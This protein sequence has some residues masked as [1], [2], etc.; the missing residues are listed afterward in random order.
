M[1]ANKLFGYKFHPKCAVQCSPPVCSQNLKCHDDA[2]MFVCTPT[3]LLFE[4]SFESVSLISR[5]DLEVG[6]I[7][8]RADKVGLSIHSENNSTPLLVLRIIVHLC[9]F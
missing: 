5:K 3:D 2:A 7:G 6:S 9:W 8:H 1:C 4:V